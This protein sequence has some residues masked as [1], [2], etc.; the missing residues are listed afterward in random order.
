MNLRH[1]DIRRIAMDTGYSRPTIWKVLNKMPGVD[2]LT[3]LTILNAAEKISFEN[4][5]ISKHVKNYCGKRN[6]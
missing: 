3:A 5:R 6:N 1:G 2:D 4:D